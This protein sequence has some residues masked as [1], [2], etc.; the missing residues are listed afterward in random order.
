MP[1]KPMAV[2]FE[3]SGWVMVKIQCCYGTKST[4]IANKLTK[5]Y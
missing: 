2:S 1:N 4:I 3:L 5:N